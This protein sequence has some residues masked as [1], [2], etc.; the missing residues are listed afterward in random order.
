M[1]IRSQAGWIVTACIMGGLHLSAQANF[2]SVPVQVVAV[3]AEFIPRTV[4]TTTPGHSYT[5]CSGNTSYLGQFSEDG[6]TV[7]GSAKTNLSCSTT[8]YPATE[9]TYQTYQRVQYTVVRSES[10]LMLLSCT[11]NWV[12]STCPS[13]VVGSNY[14]LSS[15][16]RSGSATASNILRRGL[17]GATP[18]D[19]D[20]L[21]AVR[22]DGAQGIKP[23][24]L[25]YVSAVLLPQESS[26][27]SQQFDL[28]DAISRFIAS[29]TVWK[30]AC[31]A[32]GSIFQ[33]CRTEVLTAKHSLDDAH[34][35]WS[36]V[37]DYLQHQRGHPKNPAVCQS[38]GADM[39]L[40]FDSYLFM[41]DE[42]FGI[43]QSVD[44]NSSTAQSD[45]SSANAL[46]VKLRSQE[47]AALDQAQKATPD[48][49]AACAEY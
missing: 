16:K 38:A 18:G 12:W 25:N 46:Y 19:S 37:K 11:Q 5:D 35:Q 8:S 34:A 13:L 3:A 29:V 20:G 44:P 23:I 40:G 14:A 31:S 26:S 7:S 1:G 15:T 36:A 28:D 17:L 24:T 9:T 10:S 22:L 49:L 32:A 33:R 2:T 47:D 43:I 27:I 6:N 45:W 21:S 42:E 4:T 39:I 48:A 41:Q 30:T